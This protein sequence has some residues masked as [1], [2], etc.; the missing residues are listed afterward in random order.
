MRS[1]ASNSELPSVALFYDWRWIKNDPKR[2]KTKYAQF[3]EGFFSVDQTVKSIP[4]LR[5]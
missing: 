1:H 3:F 5:P 4:I 2:L